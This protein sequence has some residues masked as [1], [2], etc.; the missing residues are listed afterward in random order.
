MQTME[1]RHQSDKG[2][3]RYKGDGVVLR[4]IHL[5]VQANDEDI[6]R[7]RDQENMDSETDY[8]TQAIPNCY[9]VPDAFESRQ[10]LP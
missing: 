7:T 10:M 5:R 1:Q 8:V 3:F 9:G 2:E 4:E 6:H